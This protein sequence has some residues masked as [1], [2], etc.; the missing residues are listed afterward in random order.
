MSDMTS[1]IATL[2]NAMDQVRTKCANDMAH[3]C[4]KH[5]ELQSTLAEMRYNRVEVKEVIQVERL[6]YRDDPRPPAED[7]ILGK[8][9]C[10]FAFARTG[11]FMSLRPARKAADRP[12]QVESPYTQ[13]ATEITALEEESCR[14][15]GPGR[16]WGRLLRQQQ[17]SGR[18]VRLCDRVA[19]GSA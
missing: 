17:C 7:V 4:V 9:L 5:A 2:E 13:L 6:A 12:R 16:T 14:R 8:A 10:T 1:Q 18:A 15:V 3:L 11:R 19:P